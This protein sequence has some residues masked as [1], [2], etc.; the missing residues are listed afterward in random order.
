[1]LQK[2]I[3]QE[4]IFLKNISPPYI[5]RQYLFL[6]SSLCVLFHIYIFF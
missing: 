2:Y 3:K 1:M 4:S 6:V 5:F